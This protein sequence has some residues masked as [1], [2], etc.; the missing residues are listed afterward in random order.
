M[1]RLLIFCLSLSLAPSCAHLQRTHTAGIS[2][3]EQAV[4]PLYRNPNGEDK[5]FIEGSLEDGVPRLFLVDTG[6]SVSMISQAIAVENEL[7]VRP[8]NTQLKGLN[9]RTS[10]I[11]TRLETLKFGSIRLSDVSVAIGIKG[12]PSHV[13]LVPIAGLIGNDILSQFH[14]EV[15]YPAQ[16]L[17]LNRSGKTRTPDHAVPL[18][19]NG[20]HAVAQANLTARNPEGLTV[21]QHALLAV[22]TGARGIMLVGASPNNLTDVATEGVEP[23]AGVGADGPIVHPTRRLSISRTS[24]GGLTISIPHSATWIRYENPRRSHTPEMRGFVGYSVLSQYRVT[25]DYPQKRFAL[26]TS[27]GVQPSVDVHEWFIRRGGAKKNPLDK[28]R[29]LFI[30]G[31]NQEAR[32]RL[33]KLAEKP[34]RYPGAVALL[35]RI[36][37]REGQHAK[38]SDRLS[39]LP[40]RDLVE[41]GEIISAVNGLWLAG[42]IDKAVSQATK[43]TI[44]EPK[45]SAAWVA[46]SDASLAQGS[47][48][49]AREAMAR[50]IELDANP[51]GHR[52]RRAVISISEGD[53]DGALSHLQRQIR[54]HPNDGYAHW[55]YARTARGPDRTNLVTADL[56]STEAKL[57]PG[58]GPLDFLAGAWF[59]LDDSVRAQEL[60]NKGIQRDCTRASSQPSRANCEAWY[61]G[62]VRHR[63]EDAEEKINTALEAFPRRSEF[64]DTLALILEAKGDMAGA[65]KASWSAAQNS[66]DDVYLLTQALRIK[67]LNTPPSP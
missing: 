29:A 63:L 31:R 48:W 66:P 44:L 37:R 13:G 34:Q 59:Q 67:L 5:I 38:A 15:D 36:E 26:S 17:T 54:K 35:S 45:S 21:E 23:I 8:R 24:L 28:V 56:K 20:Q 39:K 27:A 46:L 16:T 18:F 1:F 32:K 60:M 25:L 50:A 33:N 58:D 49:E 30:I 53:Y 9:G 64:L 40:I 41:T 65:A 61:Q 7:P 10:W 57:H 14:V 55:L 43:A 47:A 2:G 6:S 51:E 52:L 12:V 42:D 3:A 11:S 19:F 62:L 22:D 4:L